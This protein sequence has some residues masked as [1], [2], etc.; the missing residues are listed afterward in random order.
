[1]NS[2]AK[3]GK[4]PVIILGKKKITEE[5]QD[6]IDNCSRSMAQ[7]EWEIAYCVVK[8]CVLLV[9]KKGFLSIFQR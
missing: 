7:E 3:G 4:G 1:M 9:I 6:Q 2:T 5:E 8:M